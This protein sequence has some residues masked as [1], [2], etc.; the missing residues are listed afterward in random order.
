MAL[1]NAWQ[2]FVCINWCIE[3]LDMGKN[4]LN[5]QMLYYISNILTKHCHLFWNPVIKQ[6]FLVSELASSSTGFHINK[7]YRAIWH[8]S[9]ST[10]YSRNGPLGVWLL[11]ICNLA[12]CC[13]VMWLPLIPSII[14]GNSFEQSPI[15]LYNNDFLLVRCWIQNHA[16]CIISKGKWTV[17][18]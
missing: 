4:W 6:D 14:D 12:T 17:Q 9:V 13:V 1:I 5:Y 7:L 16:Q 11:I 2:A 8:T 15:H 18:F 10:I 3:Q